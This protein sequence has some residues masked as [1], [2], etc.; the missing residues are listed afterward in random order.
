MKKMMCVLAALCLLVTC[1][2]AEEYVTI[3]ELREQIKEGWNETY[4]AKGREVVANV[5]MDW[6]PEDA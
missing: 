2:A 4:T 5:K 6:S 3:G 1:A